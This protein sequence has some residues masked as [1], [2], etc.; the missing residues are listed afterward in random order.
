MILGLIP[1]GYMRSICD[2]AV[3]LVP[4]LFPY[5]LLSLIAYQES[6]IPFVVL[7]L[8]QFPIYVVL[9]YQVKRKKRFPAPG[10]ILLVLHSVVA[11]IAFMAWAERYGK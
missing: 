3:I 5:S 6:Y 1:C 9:W 11:V 7:A 8:V 2:V 4:F 10:W